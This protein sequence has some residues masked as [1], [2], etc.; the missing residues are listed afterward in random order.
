MQVKSNKQEV[1]NKFKTAFRETAQAYSEANHDVINN[2]RNWGG[3]FGTTYRRNGDVVTG[4]NRNIFDLGN[5][6]ASQTLSFSSPFTAVFEWDGKGETPPIV[7]HEGAVL[8]NGGV[9]PA[10]RW[11]RVAAEELDIPSVFA[12]YFND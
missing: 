4:G 3:G 11:T 9:I 2:A 12:R 5:L 10:R 6:D 8:W 1:V 7:V